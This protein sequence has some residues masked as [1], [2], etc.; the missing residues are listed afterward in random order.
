MTTRMNN[1][2]PNSQPNE[3]LPLRTPL[4]DKSWDA[5]AEEKNDSQPVMDM[6]EPKDGKP[7][8]GFC[9]LCLAE[10]DAANHFTR[11]EC[12]VVDLSLW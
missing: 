2:E 1:F 9:V 11:P 7:V 6:L 8:F 10:L 5:D 4:A 12:F 3:L